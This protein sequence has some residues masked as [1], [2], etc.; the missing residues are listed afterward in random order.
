[1]GKRSPYLSSW[2]LRR[3]ILGDNFR[4]CLPQILIPFPLL[5]VKRQCSNSAVRGMS[6][7]LN[8]ELVFNLLPS[9]NRWCSNSPARVLS[10]QSRELNCQWHLAE[11]R[12]SKVVRGGLVSTPLTLSWYKQALVRSWAPPPNLQQQNWMRLCEAGVLSTLFSPHRTL[13]VSRNQWGAELPLSS[14]T[15]IS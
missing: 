15:N 6:V 14:N 12:L 2:V 9:R 4:I 5:G 1:M 3:K 13:G 11:I 10:W 7:Y 8:R